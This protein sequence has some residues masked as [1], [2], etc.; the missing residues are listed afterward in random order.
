MTRILTIIALLFAA[1]AWASEVDGNSFFCEPS[2][3]SPNDGGYSAVIFKDGLVSI[4]REWGGVGEHTVDYFSDNRI[5]AWS[6]LGIWNYEINRKT[7]MLKLIFKGEAFSV[8]NCRFETEEKAIYAVTEAG[9]ERV[10]RQREG[11]QF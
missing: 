5:V 10:K 2:S 6:V 7:L 8:W 11:N 9:Q 1:P 4:Y 3:E